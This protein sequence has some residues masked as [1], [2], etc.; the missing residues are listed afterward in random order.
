MMYYSNQHKFISRI[1]TALGNTSSRDVYREGLFA[2]VP[3]EGVDKVL[4]LIKHRTG[5]ERQKLLEDL[6]VEAEAINL[7]VI[8]KKSPALVT[9]DITRLVVEKDPEWG[10]KKSVVAW[11]HPLIDKLSLNNALEKQGVPV[12]LVEMDAEKDFMP[13]DGLPRGVMRERVTGSYIGVTSADFCIAESATMVMKTR[14]GQAR[15]VS[16]I[17]SIHIAVIRMEQIIAS[18][19]ELYTILKWDPKERAEGLT[20]CMTFI[21]G[22]SKT[23]DIEAIMVYGAH[24]PR[25]DFLYVITG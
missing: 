24:G 18:L 4:H 17:P 8:P 13:Y 20:H 5:D 25:E 22:P 19:K 16:L 21:S 3:P 6:M 11:R 10:D 14:P 12:H 23:A 15:S 9:E 1:K 7:N 2:D